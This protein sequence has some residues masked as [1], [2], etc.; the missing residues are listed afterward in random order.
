[1]KYIGPFRINDTRGTQAYRLDLPNTYQI[2]DTFYISLLRPFYER[3]G[4]PPANISAPDLI[5]TGQELWEVEKIVGERTRAR[6]KEYRL[7]WK[8]YDKE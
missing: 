6:K 7:R 4:E 5:D 1:M 8:K 2:Y 3:L